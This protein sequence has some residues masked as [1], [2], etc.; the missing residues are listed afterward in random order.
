M[1]KI[2]Q[3]KKP[4]TNSRPGILK[5]VNKL[6]TIRFYGFKELKTALSYAKQQK[7]NIL[8]IFSGWGCVSTRGTEWKTIAESGLKD[9][10]QENFILLWLPVDDKTILEKPYFAKQS[11]NDVYIETIGKENSNLQINL[12]NTNSQPLLCFIDT[13]IDRVGSLYYKTFCQDKIE[14]EKFIKSGI[15]NK[16]NCG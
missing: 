5:E 16:A 1:P 14:F 12:T 10:I 11:G 2:S 3:I 6:D 8:L 13:N 15:K 9:Y 4:G 7:K